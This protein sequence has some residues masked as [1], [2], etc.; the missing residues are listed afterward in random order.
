MIARLALL[1]LPQGQVHSKLPIQRAARLRLNSLFKLISFNNRSGIKYLNPVKQDSQASRLNRRRGALYLLHL[2]HHSHSGDNRP[3][4]L[5]RRR[6]GVLRTS[7]ASQSS[8]NKDGDSKG[9]N[10]ASSL[11]SLSRL[12]PGR[13]VTNDIHES[14]ML[15]TI[16]LLEVGWLDR[17]S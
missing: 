9:N 7:R 14:S 8:T 10:G 1:M 6:V 15:V 2:H 17:T 16:E 3:N 5:K 12:S 4:I 11:N 13:R